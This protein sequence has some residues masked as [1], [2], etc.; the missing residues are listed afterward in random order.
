MLK[1]ILILGVSSF[2]GYTF[3]QHIKNKKFK[4]YGTYNKKINI[5]SIE[6][7]NIKLFKIDLNIN[8]N[9]L[10]KLTKKI[11]PDYIVDFAS[12]CMVNESWI[13]PTKYYNINFF[14]KIDFIEYLKKSNFLKKFIY[15]STPEVFGNTR[16]KLN[17][18]YAYFKPSTPY[19]SSKLVME[20]FISS[21][22]PSKK[23]FI[24]RFSNFYGKFQ[25]NYRL[26]PKTIL[27]IIKKKKILIHGDGSSKRNY[28]YSE[29]FSEGILKILTCKNNSQVYHFAGTKLY[30]VQDIV[31]KIS[32]IMKVDYKKIVKFTV[33]RKGKDQVYSLNCSK[34]MRQLGW[35]PKVNLDAGIKKI[36]KYIENNKI[37]VD[38][39][40]NNFV[41]D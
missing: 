14:S 29:D 33:D 37:L 39:R 3:F 4:I 21:Y 17:E 12:I 23:F 35:S 40:P 24:A 26:I 20:K 30:S 25:P 6:K 8:K 36:I 32:K 15:I 19:A 28:I 9:N 38:K 10:T 1:K 18:K 41:L 7:K 34:T 27:S 2:A 13:N 31:K 11:K 16:K 22:N 5:G